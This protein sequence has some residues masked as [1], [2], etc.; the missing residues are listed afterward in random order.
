MSRAYRIAGEPMYVAV[1]KAYDRGRRNDERR[2]RSHLH[3]T[4]A[5]ENEMVWND[6]TCMWRETPI[7]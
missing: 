7:R 1:R 4:G 3:C 6:P 5:F 2:F